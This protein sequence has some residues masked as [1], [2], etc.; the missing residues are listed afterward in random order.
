MKKNKTSTENLKDKFEGISQK[1]KQEDKDVEN[2]DME[3]EA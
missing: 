1:A 3:R 2:K